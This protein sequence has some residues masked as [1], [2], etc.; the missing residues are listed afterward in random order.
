MYTSGCVQPG[1]LAVR[2]PMQ[3]IVTHSKVLAQAKGRAQAPSTKQIEQ[4]VYSLRC[5]N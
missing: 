2:L 4:Q 1:R 3:L 5:V